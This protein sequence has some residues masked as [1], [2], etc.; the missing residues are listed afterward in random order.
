[1]NFNEV[2]WWKFLE[3]LILLPIDG[4]FLLCDIFTQHAEE[5]IVVGLVQTEGVVLM[6]A[7]DHFNHCFFII[8][9]CLYYIA[10][11]DCNHLQEDMSR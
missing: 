3:D 4:D 6:M 2:F 8:G 9:H 11:R 5:G 10:D 1:M 7:V